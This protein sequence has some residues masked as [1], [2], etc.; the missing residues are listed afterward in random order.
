MNRYA[1]GEGIRINNFFATYVIGPLLILNPPF[2][3]WYIRNQL[4]V[5]IG[6]LAFE[7]AAVDSYNCRVEEYSDPK[8]GLYYW[9][10][11]NEPW[12]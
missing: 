11:T 4:G 9:G 6:Q 8:T 3:K 2:T 5:P 1:K 7:D 12:T 10:G